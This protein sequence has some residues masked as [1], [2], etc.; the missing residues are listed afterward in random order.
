MGGQ[1]N[2]GNNMGGQGGFGGQN[3]Y[4]GF[5]PQT[6]PNW[7]GWSGGNQNPYNKGPSNNH[8]KEINPY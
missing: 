7:Q 6:G 3:R 1:G 5:I 8:N 2:Q 4:D